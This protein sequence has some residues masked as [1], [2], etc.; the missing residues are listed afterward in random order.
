MSGIGEWLN[1]E[2]FYSL[3]EGRAKILG[4]LPLAGYAGLHSQFGGTTGNVRLGWSGGLR[5]SSPPASTWCV[6]GVAVC[7]LFKR[8]VGSHEGRLDEGKGLGRDEASQVRG[9]IEPEMRV[10]HAGPAL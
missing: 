6:L 9:G 8:L 2:I 5:H 3:K 10:Q 4:F 7:G 1:G